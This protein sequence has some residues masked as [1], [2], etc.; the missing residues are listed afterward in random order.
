MEKIAAIYARVSTEEQ[1]LQNQIVLC[2]KYAETQG[3]KVFKIYTDICSGRESS[4]PNFNIMIED[5]RHFSFNTI[6]VTKLDR[7]GSS[8]A[9]LFSLFNEFIYKN[10]RLEVI[11]QNFCL[12]SDSVHM[13]GV[14]ALLEFNKDIISERTKEGIF[15]QKNAKIL[16]VRGKDK[17]PRKNEGYIK[18][19]RLVKE[20]AK[21]SDI[22]PSK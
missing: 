12:G 14:N 15:A 10:I 22:L 9:H 19:W 7:I 21:S 16:K 3:I 13:Q 2:K 5:M 6:I 20:N 17:R 4:R 18:R 8:I 1:E 11:C